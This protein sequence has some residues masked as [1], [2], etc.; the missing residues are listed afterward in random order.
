MLQGCEVTTPTTL[1]TAASV[2]AA[3]RRVNDAW[4]GAHLDPGGVDWARST[5]MT[6]NLALH[7]LTGDVRYRSYAEQWAE[8]ADYRLGGATPTRHADDQCAGQVFNELY[9]LEPDPAKV[10]SIDEALAAMVDGPSTARDD[11][12]W[13]DAL[14]MAMPTF[15]QA[16]NR[17]DD[18]AYLTTM[19]ELF[20][21]ARVRRGLWR[22][23]AQLWYRDAAA[24]T[25]TSPSGLP[26]LWSRGNGWAF[27]AH[28][29]VL[30]R[31]R[32]E[33]DQWPVYGATL[34]SM[35]EAL[36]TKQR[37]DGFWNMN[38]ADAQQAPGRETSGTAMFAFGMAYGVRSGRLDRATFAPV[39]A[40]AWNGMTSLAVQPDGRLG[41]VQGVARAPASQPPTATS[42]TDYAVG[43]YLLA[44]CEL[45]RML[46]P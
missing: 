8:A 7:R 5:Y 45:V 11:W 17:L 26:V 29:K 34:R 30:A 12:W 13:V 25:S 3:M 35:A 24:I 40:R 41:Y 19:F 14:H 4:M 42:T 1:P 22:T 18:P 44:G 31:L 37:S 43:A 39:V 10:A 33:D 28:A 27:A 16:A 36:R 15:V 32:P 6:G 2:I 46:T 38:L 23:R 20:Q 9:D 21:D